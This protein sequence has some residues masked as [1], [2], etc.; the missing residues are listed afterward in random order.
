MT[1][2]PHKFGPYGGQFVPETLMPALIEL[3][4]AFVS[5]KADAEFQKEFNKLMAT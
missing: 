4:E 1:L 2:L 3:E 5:A